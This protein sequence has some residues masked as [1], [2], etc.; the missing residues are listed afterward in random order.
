[1]KKHNLAITVVAIA[2]ALGV[3][4]FGARDAIAHEH[5]EV[6]EY[7]LSF[8]W[9][10][11]P[12]FAGVPN[13]IEVEIHD[14]D[15]NP[16]EGAEGSLRVRVRIGPASRALTLSPAWNEPGRYVAALTPTR[17]GD[18]AFDFTG[19]I[20]TTT[21]RETFTSADGS[22]STVEPASDTLFPDEEIDNLSLQRQIDALTEQIEA[23]QE[24]VDLLS[25]E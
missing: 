11:E 4:F 18:Y 22:F 24:Q 19:R 17:A 1:M 7:E 15:G 6:G 13:G 9:Q 12:A 2:L 14:A 25:E 5:R 23:L 10:V 16:V 8:G 20:G 21:L 3:W